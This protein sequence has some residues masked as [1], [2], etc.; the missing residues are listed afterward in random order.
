MFGSVIIDIFLPILKERPCQLCTDT[1]RKGFLLASGIVLRTL[2]SKHAKLEPQRLYLVSP[3]V[4]GIP[5][6]EGAWT[7]M[8]LCSL[9]HQGFRRSDARGGMMYSSSRVG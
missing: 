2:S 5:Y 6:Y 3:C 4:V 1:H 8:D 7:F 9:L